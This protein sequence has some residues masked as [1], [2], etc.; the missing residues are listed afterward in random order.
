MR[1][2]DEF[3]LNFSVS[4][5]VPPIHQ[6]ALWYTSH[7]LGSTLTAHALNG[8]PGTDLTQ[9][10]IDKTQH[11][12]DQLALCREE[13]RSQRDLLE[14]LLRLTDKQLHTAGNP[15][16]LSYQDPVA[17][18]PKA[19]PLWAK[20]RA[21]TEGLA[22][23]AIQ[24]SSPCGDHHVHAGEP[25]ELRRLILAGGDIYYYRRND[26]RR[27]VLHSFVA[28]GCVDLVHVLFDAVFQRHEQS[29]SLE[30][31]VD[32]SVA[33]DDGCT[34]AHLVCT[35]CPEEAAAEMLRTLVRYDA[36]NVGADPE[37]SFLYQKDSGKRMRINWLQENA[38]QH[39]F[40][41]AAASH[42]RLSL[43]GD[44]IQSIDFFQRLPEG[45]IELKV[46]VF[47]EDWNRLTEAE[48]RTFVTREK[49]A[50]DKLAEICEQYKQAS[51]SSDPGAGGRTLE[52]VT[53]CVLAGADVTWQVPGGSVRVLSKFMADG[54]TAPQVEALL[55]MVMQ[56]LEQ[57]AA[58]SNPLPLGLDMTAG[59][60][61]VGGLAGLHFL[62]TTPA[63]P[64]PD[65]K[66]GEVL[67]QPPSLSSQLLPDRIDW[68][69]KDMAGQECISLA[70]AYGYL[71]VWWAAAK[72]YHIS[73][74]MNHDGPISITRPVRRGDWDNVS[75]EDQHRFLLTRGI[76]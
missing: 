37:L 34:V 24:H 65:S 38:E 40:I 25:E 50:T 12:E 56:R 49:R 26:M 52:L 18:C 29:G 74:Y 66:R 1:H 44:G 76:R 71:S 48:Q 36:L 62:S 32:F 7:T 42:G 43:L 9:R 11:L 53:K 27:P 21:A 28:S 63:E 60:T 30:P 23:M 45:A 31:A 19:E 5:E 10:L 69:K 64:H 39:D 70:A 58:A 17:D 67:F 22:W 3:G 59:N 8:E 54:F 51:A 2:G 68:G 61:R 57:R 47:K 6:T 41:N 72:R 13:V 55:D 46:G 16:R 15:P 14:R 35:E 4:S 20:L 75:P 73:Y 33:D